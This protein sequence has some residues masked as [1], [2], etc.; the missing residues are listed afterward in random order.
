MTIPEL[1][2]K[3]YVMNLERCPERRHHIIQEFQRLNIHDYEFFEA[4]DKDSSEVQNM[5]KTDFVKKFPPCFRCH[6]NKCKCPNNVLIKQQIGNWCSFINIM[7]D[8][9]EK[10]Y[11]ELI[12]ICEDDVKFTENGMDILQKM[13]TRKNLQKYKI[14]FKKPILIRAEQ[15]GN[16]PPL[17]TLKLTKNKTMSNACFLVN[18][19]YAKSFM[20][21]LKVI[22][23]TS[24]IYIHIKILNYDKNIQH[25]TIEPSP[26]HQ[27]SDNK[28]AI[29][30]SE[31]HPKG[32]DK[33]DREEQKNHFKRIEYKDFLCIGH[34]GCLTTSASDYLTQMGYNVGHEN[35]GGDG[36]S[37]WMLAVEDENYPW[38]NVHKKH[39]Y[40]FKN[41]IH[42]VRNPFDSI[43]SIILENKHTPNHKSYLFKKKHIKK[44]LN[45]DLPNVDFNTL[46]L[47]EETEL[48]L[49]TFIYWNKVCELAKP[50]T[51]LK[52]E[53]VSSLQKF[54]TRNVS[55]NTNK[56]NT[57]KKYDGKVYEKPTISKD[58]Y[59]K[60]DT[61]LKQ[62]LQ[63]FCK[64]YN[65]EYLLDGYNTHVPHTHLTHHNIKYFKIYGERNSGTN[66]VTQLLLKNT[67]LLEHSSYYKGG[68][69]WK[70]GFP[71][72]NLF[73]DNIRKQTLFVVIIRDL[74]K[75]L[76]SMF[77][78]PYSLDPGKSLFSFVNGDLKINE[79][80]KDHDVNI[81]KEENKNIVKLRYSKINSYLE[82]YKKVENIIFVNLEDLQDNNNKMLD[83][84]KD[85]FQINIKPK[86]IKVEKHT[87]I[88]KT[89]ENRDYNL[90]CPIIKN[91]N[92][93]LEQF[94][95]N[96]KDEFYYKSNRIKN[97]DKDEN[98]VTVNNHFK[99]YVPPSKTDGI[100]ISL[101]NN[102]TYEPNVTK[103]LLY[104]FEK[105]NIDTFIDVGANIGYYTLLFS[106]KNIK[107]YSFE[108]NFENYTILHKNLEINHFSQSLIYNMGLSDHVGE[109]EFYYRK[110]KSG[111]GSFNKDIQNK[112]NLNLCKKVPV[113]KL[114]NI[115][116]EGDNIMLKID[117]EGYELHA[118]TGML[119]LLRTKKIKVFCIEISRKFYGNDV[120]NK[121]INLLK[122]FFTNLYIVQLKKEL[123]QVPPLSQY[124]LI[125]T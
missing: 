105:K 69:G 33:A 120:E 62:E 113:D 52:I 81:Y 17:N 13:I 49:K 83:F 67:N 30:R 24:D 103:E 122:K 5:I 89:I 38:G 37:S 23:T 15:R 114:D 20:S 76:V 92:N 125:C 7:K 77:K 8:I 116:I 112:Q 21:N 60:L 41:I 121:I 86:L 75:W 51:I 36:I 93:Q 3:I 87:K 117:I 124:D 48:A 102:R 58:I 22:D 63:N 4:T 66:F 74:E 53:D 100:F 110:E 6:Q 99:M 90:K 57:N 96:L 50:N 115:Y 104:W 18:K 12:M 88:N 80:R 40:Y 72:L 70:H 107:T 123:I 98:I 34:P 43:P 85:K 44:I 64:K 28:N 65:Y 42:V 10:D 9:I 101:R 55:L 73:N 54:N 2:K 61:A 95:K 25:F 108:P 106:Q 45:I 91:K 35:M 84:L 39:E 47:L 59:E 27:L 19:C 14:D 94:V 111:H 109:L 16:F 11:K 32:L 119:N 118:I 97:T 56:K 29:F 71:R 46:S 79:K 82:F 31:I 78:S 26:T 1:V 68:T